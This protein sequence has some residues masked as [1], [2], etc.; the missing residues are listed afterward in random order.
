MTAEDGVR[1]KVAVKRFHAAAL[2]DD[3]NLKLLVSEIDIMIRA[4]HKYVYAQGPS[5]RAGPRAEADM[6]WR[7]GL[8]THGS[9]CVHASIQTRERGP[10]CK[11]AA[12][13]RRAHGPVCMPASIWA[14]HARAR[15]GRATRTSLRKF[16]NNLFMRQAADPRCMTKIVTGSNVKVSRVTSHPSFSPAACRPALVPPPRA[17]IA[18]AFILHVQTQRGA[19]WY[20]NGR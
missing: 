6:R 16:S 4:Q 19:A 5:S 11:P 14:C 2:N 3:L 10:T 20:W 7:E 18:T 12:A 15:G 9:E 8:R 13:S 1:T 17:A